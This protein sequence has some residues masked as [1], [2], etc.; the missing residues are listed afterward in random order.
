[1]SSRKR[2]REGNILTARQPQANLHEVTDAIFG[3]DLRKQEER[4]IRAVPIHIKSIYPDIRQPR[5]AMPSMVREQFSG[6]PAQLGA[7]FDQWAHWVRQERATLGVDTA[8]SVEPFVLGQE[9]AARNEAQGPIEAALMAI[10]ELAASIYR[11]GLT[12]PITVT[13]HYDNYIIETGER[14]WLAY[15]LLHHL[16]DKDE[17]QR[18]AMI[19]AR[20]VERLDV[21]RQASE[22]NARANLNLIGRARQYAVL[23]MDLNT[24]FTPVPYHE[25]DSDHA[26]YAQ[27][28][29]LK[30]PYGYNEQLLNA[31]GITS[32]SAFTLYRKV[33]SLP[34]ELWTRADD[35]NWSESKI[36]QLLNNSDKGQPL[37][38]SA[39]LGRF[40][41][42]RSRIIPQ[43]SQAVRQ[44][45]GEEREAAIRD[46]ERLLEELRQQ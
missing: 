19:P 45:K 15:H 33:L 43:I 41:H 28:L 22:N 34:T 26:Y 17:D 1:M 10:V 37:S 4:Q 12:N 44:L 9:E 23:L 7:F 46:L 38:P 13:P 11:D 29:D 6:D 18:W 42:F 3:S 20:E 35:E 5:R 25:C 39:K 30:V 16:F 21:W 40:E 14:R 36:V 32:R 27:A 24:D 2:G 31:C 8:F